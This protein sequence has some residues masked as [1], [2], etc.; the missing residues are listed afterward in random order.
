MEPWIEDETAA[1]MLN[2]RQRRWTLAQ[3]TTFFSKFE[4]Q[5]RRFLLGMF[6][7]GQDR[8]V[9]LFILKLRPEDSVMLVTHL[10]GDRQWRGKG[11]SREAS[12]GLFDYFFNT[13]GYVKAKAN[14]RPAN[15]PMMWL[16]LNG[17]WRREA[18]LAKHLRLKATGERADLLVF[19]VTADEW[20]ANRQ[21]AKTV[22]RRRMTS[23]AHSCGLP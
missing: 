5:K 8:L 12:I 21:S 4:G 3:Q 22:S 19:G 7:K 14:V 10:V 23:R 9:G 11:A 6:P 17:G 20:Q 2:T 15:R 13:L 1:E 16:L 18:T